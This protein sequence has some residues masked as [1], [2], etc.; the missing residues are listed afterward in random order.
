MQG[1]ILFCHNPGFGSQTIS[2]FRDIGLLDEKK[3]IVFFLV[4]SPKVQIELKKMVVLTRL[5]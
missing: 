2:R 4:C 5:R 1:K 3:E